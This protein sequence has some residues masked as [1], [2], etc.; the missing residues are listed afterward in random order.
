MAATITLQACTGTNAATEATVTGIMMRANDSAATDTN[1]PIQIPSVGTNRSFEKW[2]RF[3]CTVAPSVQVSNF[4]Y[5]GP[6]T[7]PATGTILYVGT[8]GSG[9]TPVA[10]DSAVATTRQDT[11]YFDTSNVLAI[12]GTLVNP[13]D[14]SYFFV[15]QLDVANTASPGNIA[16]QTHNFSYDEQ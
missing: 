3:K 9:V 11:N 4:K 8:T 14:E 1:N 7:I 5:W 6:N 15:F 12:T 13:G 10:T 16:Q 2:L